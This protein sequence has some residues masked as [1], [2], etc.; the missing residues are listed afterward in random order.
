MSLLLLIVGA[1]L[2]G[3]TAAASGTLD[4]TFLV[5]GRTAPESAILVPAGWEGGS[6]P[7][8]LAALDT[9]A[10]FGAER[11]PWARIGANAWGYLPNRD[12]SEV[13]G[14]AGLG[15]AGAGNLDVAGRYNVEWFPLTSAAG[16]GRA[17]GMI[18]TSH[19]GEGW[20]LTPKFVLV[21]RRYFQ[22]PTADFSTG[23]AGAELALGPKARFGVD[24][25]LSGQAN[26]A[27]ALGSSGPWGGQARGLVRL[28]FNGDTWQL[29]AAY[30]FAAAFA[31]E[32]EEE[33]AAVF[34]L[35]GDYADDVDA[36]SGGGFTQ[37]RVGLSG[38]VEAGKWTFSAAGLARLRIANADELAASYGQSLGGQARVER[39]LGTAVG[40]FGSVGVNTAS[41]S[42]RSYTD[43][44]GWLGVT[45]HLA[46]AR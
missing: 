41:S 7:S 21:D 17:E 32:T 38:A 11:G 2:A 40:L 14:V 18:R 23:E 6:E 15:W 12:A 39:A 35:Q 16:N 1:A 5:G 20:S 30:R 31:G 44:W 43:T 10:R 25:G 36:L 42:S 28:R 46:S 22:A 8:G 4:T 37:H 45:W 29:S 34:T 24:V 3:D 33:T 13:G 19:S 9:R 26:E 27:R